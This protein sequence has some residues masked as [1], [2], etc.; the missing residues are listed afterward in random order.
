ML[1]KSGGGGDGFQFPCALPFFIANQ[2]LRM[3]EHQA[4]QVHTSSIINILIAGFAQVRSIALN[5]IESTRA[6]TRRCR[7]IEGTF[8]FTALKSTVRGQVLDY[9]AY[10]IVTTMYSVSLVI[11][12]ELITGQTI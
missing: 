3:A 4:A 9:F 12:K 10:N 1:L 7:G 5:E 6:A 8:F 2:R 11:L